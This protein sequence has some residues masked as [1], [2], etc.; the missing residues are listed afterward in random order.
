MRA[1]VARLLVA[2]TAAAALMAPAHAARIGILSNKYATETAADFNTRIPAHTFTA[3]DTSGAT[4]NLAQLQSNFDVLLV[5]EDSTYGNAPTIGNVAAAFASGGRSVV[6][7]AF[8]DQDRSDAP[9]SIPPHGWGALEALDPNTTDGTGTPYSARTLDVA[10]MQKHPLTAGI[11][12]L[13]SA[14]FAGG[15][16]AKPGTVVVANWTQPNARG[17]ADPAIAYRITGKACVIQLAIAP[18]YPVLGVAGTDFSG[19]FHR[20]WQNAFDFGAANCSVPLAFVAG[21]PATVPT[22]SEWGLILTILLLGGAAG[23]SLRR[24]RRA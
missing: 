2:A 20:A 15:N 3:V 16:A 7:G 21:D 13:A 5:F 6:L 11:A 14:R 22:L 1:S 12:T 4:P 23:F 8:Y 10:G 18:N 19:D 24:T 17:G 9:A